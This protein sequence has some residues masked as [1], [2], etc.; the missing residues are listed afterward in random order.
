[1][2]FHQQKCFTP[3]LG[4]NTKKSLSSNNCSKFFKKSFSIFFA[5]RRSYEA[6]QNKSI[7]KKREREKG[8]VS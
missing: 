1:M 6:M 4:G 2:P 8:Q 3:T 7:E 5:Y